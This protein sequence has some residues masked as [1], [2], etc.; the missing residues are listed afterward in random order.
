MPGLQEESIPRA[1]IS[2]GREYPFNKKTSPLLWTFLWPGKYLVMTM[3]LI[4]Y[5]SSS[6]VWTSTVIFHLIS[7][8]TLGLMCDWSA[9]PQ[10]KWLTFYLAQ[11]F[12]VP[13]YLSEVELVYFKHLYALLSTTQSF[14]NL[15]SI[16]VR[17][18]Q[19]N[20]SCFEPS[21]FSTLG[22]L[23]PFLMHLVLGGSPRAKAGPSLWGPHAFSEIK[24]EI[25]NSI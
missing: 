25:T 14:W 6:S 19:I 22:L 2:L 7:W 10:T 8:N 20:L 23:N 18:K 3:A 1:L 15:W 16:A 9:S 13:D 12:L 11:Y 24:T 17:C 21:I 5:S 4:F